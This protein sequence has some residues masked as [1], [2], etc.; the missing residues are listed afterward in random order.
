MGR[1][2][3]SLKW[4]IGPEPGGAPS[5]VLSR[6][7]PVEKRDHVFWRKL[8][9]GASGRVSGGVAQEINDSNEI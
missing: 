6:K 1:A 4:T 3:A 2:L 9:K 7:D 8:I 5:F